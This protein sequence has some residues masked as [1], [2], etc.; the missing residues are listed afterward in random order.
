[1]TRKIGIAAIAALA[2]VVGCSGAADK[3]AARSADQEA[4][5]AG[6]GDGSEEE[7]MIEVPDAEISGEL[8]LPDI[9]RSPDDVDKQCSAVLDEARALREELVSVEGERRAEDTLETI[10]DIYAAIDRVLPFSELMAN[11]HPDK[12]V[13]DAAEKCQ[14]DAMKFVSDLQLDREAYEALAALDPDSLEGAAARSLEHLL[15]DYRRAGVD[16]DEATREKLADLQEKIV[17]VGQ[18]FSRRI[19]EDKRSIEVEPDELAG[20]PEDF[21]E[22]HRPEKNGK[23]VITTEYP[24]FFPVQSYADSSQLRRRLYQEF[25]SRAYPENDATLKKLL[26]LRHEYA[27]TLGYPSW[28][29]YNAEDKMVGSQ[30]AIGEFIDKVARIAKP[31]M[32]AD[33]EA[34]LERKK[35]DAPDAENVRVWDRF[36]Y[37]KKI[38]AE[39]Y[40]VDAQKVRR[41]FDFP[42]VQQGILDVNARLWGVKYEKA[43]DADVWNDE[44][45]AFDV[46]QDGRRIGRFYLDMHPRDGKYGHAA[47]FNIHSGITGERLPV[48][49]LV[50]NFPDPSESDAALM[51]H[52]DVTTFFHEFGH[53]MHHLLGSGYHWV[54]LSGIACEWDFVE[55]PSQLMEEWAWDPAVLAGF[56]THVETGEPIPA[57][58]VEK[59]KAADEFGKGVH[60]MR[61]MF[62]AALSYNYYNRDPDGIDLLGV[63]Q[64]VQRKYNPYPYEEGTHGYA[65]FGHIE[66]YSSMYYTYMWS[67][68]LAKDVFTRFEEEGLMDS[69]TAR[70]YRRYVIGAGGAVD[71]SEQVEHFLGRES[72]FDA[73]REWLERDQG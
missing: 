16:K 10:N 34:I 11:V 40:G 51:E 27:T 3:T 73:F 46:V 39:K 17:E 29:E 45:E 19:R 66:G 64:D 59:M 50:C 1:M 18:D 22:A 70:R 37:V 13:R 69:E 12:K 32:E 14:Q 56:A 52:S 63:L 15:R 53:L 57:E 6:E 48:A 62:Y 2:A 26:E 21:V 35:K 4:G 44:V 30:K 72:S 20:M 9:W 24:D 23:V 28:A 60:V 58:L 54:N 41:Y 55:V 49:A 38:Q 31:R 25:L 8:V 7:E 43:E 33:L 36:Y 47:M 5:A 65:S 67:L 61:Q 42:K 68:V 71:A